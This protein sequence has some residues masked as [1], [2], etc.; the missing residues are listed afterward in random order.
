MAVIEYLD[1]TDSSGCSS[2][3]FS[4]L[5]RYGYLNSPILASTRSCNHQPYILYPTTLNTGD[6]CT[7]PP[8]TGKTYVGVQI[9]KL[10]LHNTSPV[11]GGG[12]V[13]KPVIGPLLCVC[14]TNHALDQFLMELQQAGITNMVRIGA[15][16]VPCLQLC[17]GI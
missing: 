8:G 2:R 14:Y 12:A 9:A 11:P 7:G 6:P 16:C 17:L 10:L 13:G 5:F 1:D 15:G 3:V 4:W